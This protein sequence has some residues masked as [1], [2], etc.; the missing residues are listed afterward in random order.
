[1]NGRAPSRPAVSRAAPLLERAPTPARPHRR[2]ARLLRHNGQRHTRR[3]FYGFFQL[4]RACFWL[5]GCLV[6]HQCKGDAGQFSCQFDQSLDG[7]EALR[8]VGVV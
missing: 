6:L 3:R 5:I 7:L 1:M 2:E 4:S 8:H